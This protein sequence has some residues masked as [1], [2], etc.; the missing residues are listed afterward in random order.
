MVLMVPECS[1][2]MADAGYGAQHLCAA[3]DEASRPLEKFPCDDQQIA[4]ALLRRK[5]DA[6]S[7]DHPQHIDLE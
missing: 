5:S 7:R 2:W 4:G 3:R 6:S 1:G